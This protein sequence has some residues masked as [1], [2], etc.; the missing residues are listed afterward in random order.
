VSKSTSVEHMVLCEHE[1]HIGFSVT[2][3]ML[4]PMSS[5]SPRVHM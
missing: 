2:G 3:D 4:Q 5:S 1:W